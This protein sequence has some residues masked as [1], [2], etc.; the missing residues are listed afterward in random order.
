MKF[1]IQ[2][3]NQ[4]KLNESV[5]N[6]ASL[7]FKNK[8]SYDT[9]TYDDIVANTKAGHAVERFLIECA[10]FTNNPKMYHDVVSAAGVEVE[11]KVINHKWCNDYNVITDPKAFNLKKWTQNYKNY[12]SARYVCVFKSD[13]LNE[14][15]EYYA[16]FDLENGDKVE[17]PK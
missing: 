17:L 13:G 5:A 10:N 4:E 2:E 3:L 11:C 8:K 7:I 12:N 16:T 9:R 14:N 15:F 1:N 6:E